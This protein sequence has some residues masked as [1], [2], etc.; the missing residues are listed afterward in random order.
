MNNSPIVFNFYYLR[1]EKFSKAELNAI[2]SIK[3]LEGLF[4]VSGYCA[5][6]PKDFF[7]SVCKLLKL[8]IEWED[9]HTV[10]AN[11]YYDI[12]RSNNYLSSYNTK[13]TFKHILEQQQLIYILLKTNK[14]Y[15]N[16]FDKIIT[17][18]S[19]M[20]SMINQNNKRLLGTPNLLTELKQALRKCKY[21][22]NGSGFAEPAGLSEHFKL[23]FGDDIS[24]Y[25]IEKKAY[26]EDMENWYKFG[27]V[28]EE[29]KTK[30]TR[31]KK[32]TAEVEIDV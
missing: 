11:I 26:L 23:I 5:R 4:K 27:S 30:V 32:P 18:K 25:E 15:A 16:P 14:V 8:P 22:L 29:K 3:K 2:P 24:I 12:Y 13:K 21:L 6:N 7:D 9:I 31:K 28:K 10:I 19:D 20:N 1:I 17:H